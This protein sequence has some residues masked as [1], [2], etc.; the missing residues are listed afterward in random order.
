MF[1]LS[2]ASPI[3]SFNFQLSS[4]KPVVP[5]NVIFFYSK[6]I[7]AVIMPHEVCLQLLLNMKKTNAA[8]PCNL[9]ILVLTILFLCKDENT[10]QKVVKKRNSKFRTED[11]V[12]FGRVV[13]LSIFYY[14]K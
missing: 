3:F 13:C 2:V 10:E 14:Y 8:I 7:L 4:C 6:K 12:F 1:Y 5:V 9:C 11:M